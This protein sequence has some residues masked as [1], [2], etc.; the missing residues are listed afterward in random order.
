MAARRRSRSSGASRIAGVTCALWLSACAAPARPAAQTAAATSQPCPGT[1]RHVF[2]AC[3]CSPVESRL[4]TRAHTL[5]QSIQVATRECLSAAGQVNLLAVSGKLEA[6][7]SQTTQLDQTLTNA[8]ARL[9]IDSNADVTEPERDRWLSC[10]ERAVAQFHAASQGVSECGADGLTAGYGAA[11]GSIERRGLSVRTIVIRGGQLMTVCPGA[12]LHSR[13]AIYL[14]L[15]LRADAYVH[16]AAIAPSREGQI[17]FPG[18]GEVPLLHGG[19]PIRIPTSTREA[20]GLDD[21]TGTETLLVVASTRPLAESDDRAAAVFDQLRRHG[22]LPSDLKIATAD[23]A[24]SRGDGLQA[25]T[26]GLHRVDIDAQAVYSQFDDAGVVI[27]PI[28]FQH[29][30]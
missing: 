21:D 19:T 23:G 9:V 14:E 26:R 27:I 18:P 20:F 2:D 28:T 25:L 11:P 22:H 10:Y 5:E 12:T 6:C 13:D 30:D 7:V 15:Q 3:G 24:A 17:L 1:A 4:L 29:V 16:V 8:L